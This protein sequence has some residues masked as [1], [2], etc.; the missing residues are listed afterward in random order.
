MYYPNTNAILFVVDSSDKNRFSKAAEELNKVLEVHF[1]IF[2]N[3]FCKGFLF[4]S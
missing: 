2:R 1:Q 4:W 3:K